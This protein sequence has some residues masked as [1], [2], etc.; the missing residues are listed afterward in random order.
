MFSVIVFI[1]CSYPLL[2]VGKN[3]NPIFGKEFHTTL[4]KPQTQHSPS[5]PKTAPTINHNNLEESVQEC[6]S[7]VPT[8][9]AC[10]PGG[11][12]IRG[13]N[14]EHICGQYENQQYNTEFGP[15]HTVWIQTFFI[16]K[17]EVTY[18][19]YQQCIQEKQ[20]DSAH[21]SYS[22]FNG[23]KQPMMGVSWYDAK[24]FCTAQEKRLPTEAEWEKAARGVDGSNNPFDVETITCAEAVIFDQTGRSCG[25]EKTGKH[26]EQGRVWDVGQKPEGRY[27]VYDMVGNAEEWVE[28][29]FAPSL[30]A[31]G[32]DCLGINP[33][34]PCPGEKECP[35][36]ALKYKQA[37]KVVKGGSWYWPAQDATAWHRRPHVPTN[38]PFHHFGFRCAQDIMIE[39]TQQEQ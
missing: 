20:C 18:E 26:P 33:K 28:D 35:Q 30:E 12:M 39:N 15:R 13:T 36:F 25:I 11:A 10:I 27:G 4:Q 34:G 29:W 3:T 2:S 21:P 1:S 14:E 5:P 31:C 38:I 8:D 17:T 22:D 37:L 16:D 9:M 23:P 7:N 19:A 24:K 32:T 6:P